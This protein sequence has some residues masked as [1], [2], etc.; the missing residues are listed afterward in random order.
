MAILNQLAKL[1]LA[2]LVIGAVFTGALI[3]FTFI[4]LWVLKRV[5]IK[6]KDDDALEAYNDL[7]NAIEDTVNELSWPVTIAASIVSW[8][9]LVYVFSICFYR[10]AL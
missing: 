9:M 3:A 10:G 8:P 7:R 2:Y 1:G 5:W 4:V 6:D